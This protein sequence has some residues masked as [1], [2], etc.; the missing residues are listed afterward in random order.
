MLGVEE[1]TGFPAK[2]ND[3]T[4]KVRAASCS[5]CLRTGSSA[6]EVT[7]VVAEEIRVLTMGFESEEGPQIAFSFL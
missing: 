1:T 7:A 3:L 6:G 2:E 5:V 4:I